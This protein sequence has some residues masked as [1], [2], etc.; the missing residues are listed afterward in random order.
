MKTF[1]E[2]K[3]EL[4][5]RAKAKGACTDGYKMGLDAEDKTGLLKAIT[6]NWRW[7]F[8][9]EIVNA[10]YLDENF[11]QEELHDNGIYTSGRYEARANTYVFACGSST[12]KAY[13]SSTVKACGSS[14]V[15]DATGKCT[16]PN[17]KAIIRDYHN[18]KIYIRKGV[19]EIIEVE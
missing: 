13:D 8:K 6:E 1:E 4:L 5:D 17:D 16:T 7:V 3:H 15:D 12:V 2:L 11:T 14:Y 9:N 18:R 10:D 19:F